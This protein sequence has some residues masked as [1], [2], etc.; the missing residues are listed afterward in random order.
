[1]PHRSTTCVCSSRRDR[2][3]LRGRSAGR[4]ASRRWP[5]STTVSSASGCA[6]WLHDGRLRSEHEIVRGTVD[7][8]PEQ[9]RAL[10]EGKNTGKLMLQIAD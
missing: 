6:E 3:G 7:D 4:G 5:S 8:F 10:F 9:L 1:M 2:P